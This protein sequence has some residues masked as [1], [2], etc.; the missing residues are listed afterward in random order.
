MTIS[1]QVW[2][3][4]FRALAVFSLR[5]DADALLAGSFCS[6]ALITSAVTGL[7]SG[8][9]S[10]RGGGSLA[11]CNHHKKGTRSKSDVNIVK[12]RLDG[13]NETTGCGV[14]LTS[15]PSSIACRCSILSKVDNHWA[16]AVTYS[17]CSTH[18][19]WLRGV[20]LLQSQGPCGS[21]CP[22]DLHWITLGKQWIKTWT[23]INYPSP[24][25]NC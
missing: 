1:V 13:C 20:P 22:S 12:G 4:S 21:L 15:I 14:S 16:C 23:W 17:S 9:I 19:L 5:S 3:P 2:L 7:Q 24:L 11:I 6:P 18:L 10:L 8:G 25:L